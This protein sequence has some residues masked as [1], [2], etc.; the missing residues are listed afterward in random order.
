MKLLVTASALA[1]LSFGAIAAGLDANGDGKVSAQELKVC[2]PN[3]DKIITKDE[4]KA[5]G[6]TDA[7]WKVLDKDQSGK[8]EAQEIQN[9]F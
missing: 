9:G 3:G 4:A 6:L 1:L 5:C 8:I 2:D 7:Q